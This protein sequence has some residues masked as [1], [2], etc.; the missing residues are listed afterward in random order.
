MVKECLLR[1]WDY[2][3]LNRGFNMKV[4]FEKGLEIETKNEV[5][6]AERYYINSEI[7]NWIAPRGLR[8]QSKK[9]YLTF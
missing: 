2:N 4:S 8:K 5:V 6:K 7:I 1:V 3:P 9:V